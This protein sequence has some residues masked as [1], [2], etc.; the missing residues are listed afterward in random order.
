MTDYQSRPHD[1]VYGLDSVISS[2][3]PRPHPAFRRLQYGKAGSA[4]RA[5]FRAT[6]IGVRAWKRGYVISSD[7]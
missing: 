2:L 5:F 6:G 3:I 1:N 7:T 4:K